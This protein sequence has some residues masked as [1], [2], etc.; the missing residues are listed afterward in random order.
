MLKYQELL[1]PTEKKAL[2]RK[3]KKGFNKLQAKVK[4]KNQCMVF[5]KV[6]E[7]R[8]KHM[9]STGDVLS[10]VPVTDFWWYKMRLSNISLNFTVNFWETRIFPYVNICHMLPY[11]G[12]LYLIFIFTITYFHTFQSIIKV[13]D[14][15][16]K[17]KL[18][19]IKIP[20]FLFLMKLCVVL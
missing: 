4:S 10:N 5:R 15:K 8:M 19:C 20:R 1:N 18:I 9:F 14:K 16:V 13:N 3:K 2:K 7:I 11:S 12:G 6:C 17:M